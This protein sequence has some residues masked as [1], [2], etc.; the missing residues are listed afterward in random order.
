MSPTTPNCIQTPLGMWSSRTL[1]LVIMAIIRN[2]KV[3]A[4]YNITT[5]RKMG[6]IP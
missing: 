4:L 3:H 6:T 2:H 1:I 5:D